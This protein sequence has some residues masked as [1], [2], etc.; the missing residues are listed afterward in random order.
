M[1]QHTPESYAKA[2]VQMRD[3]AVSQRAMAFPNLPDEMPKRWYD[4]MILAEA[5]PAL[6]AALET[7][8]ADWDALEAMGTRWLKPWEHKSREECRAA[9]AAAKGQ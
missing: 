4:A 5:A 6:L 3:Y 2:L 9:I 8:V 1:A 7:V